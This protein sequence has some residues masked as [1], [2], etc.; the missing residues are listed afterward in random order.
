[1]PRVTAT[2]RAIEA[3]EESLSVAEAACSAKER[4]FV[5]WLV[6]LPPRKGYKVRAARLAGYGANSTP[7]VVNSIVQVLLKQQRVIDLISEVTKK[8][9]RVMAPEALQAVREIIADPTHRDRLKAAAVVFER[10]EPTLQRVDVSV[11]HEIVD[12]DGEAVAYLRKLKALGVSR[13]KL[14]DELGYSALPKYE[15][16]L[17]LEDAKRAAATVIDADY[18]VVEDSQ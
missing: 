14:E 11:K 12:R 16:L 13:D 9:I 5:Y 7:H 18:T 10:I 3:I 15:K 2:E 8:Q 6:G 17:E 4:Q 1:M